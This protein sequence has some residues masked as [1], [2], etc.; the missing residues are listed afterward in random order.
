MT[1]REEA[2]SAHALEMARLVAERD[3]L[4]D[5]LTACYPPVRLPA[6]RPAPRRRT[7]QKGT[8]CPRN[9]A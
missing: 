1:L 4:R 2:R 9:T 5:A 3:A 8:R 6:P 7:K